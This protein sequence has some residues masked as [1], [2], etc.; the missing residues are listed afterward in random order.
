MSQ[1]DTP[2]D[3]E[4]DATLPHGRVDFPV[5]GIGASAGGLAALGRFLEAMPAEPGMA[6]VIVMHLSPRHDSIVDRILQRSTAMPV[7]QV[8]EA[9]PLQMNH[10]YVISPHKALSMH[11]GYLRLLDMDRPRGKHVSIDFFFRTLAEAHREKAFAV[12]L[13]GTGSDGSVGIA[14]IRERGGITLVQ[15][16]EDAE[17]DQ[18]PRA[19]IGTGA[20]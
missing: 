20:V 13:S 6:V 10:V 12:I 5:V 18:M 9:L 4:V 3:P 17:Y 1:P 19:A 2:S 11:D 16:P 8:L 15:Q 14:R 7:T